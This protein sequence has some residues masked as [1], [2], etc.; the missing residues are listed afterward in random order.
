MVNFALSSEIISDIWISL[1]HNHTLKK[2]K[3]IAWRT[4][5]RNVIRPS[6]KP[7]LCG[8]SS[9]VLRLC[10]L[11]RLQSGVFHDSGSKQPAQLVEVQH[12]RPAPLSSS[13]SSSSYYSLSST[14]TNTGSQNPLSTSCQHF[15]DQKPRRPL[16]LDWP[17]NSS[18]AFF[19]EPALPPG[20]DIISIC[21]KSVGNYCVEE[22]KKMWIQERIG[23]NIVLSFPPFSFLVLFCLK[24]DRC[25][26]SALFPELITNLQ[27]LL[28]VLVPLYYFYFYYLLQVCLLVKELLRLNILSLGLFT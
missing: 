4:L 23:G 24:L 21:P 2:V 26:T 22:R 9:G 17:T 5:G 13:S 6:G 20:C 10:S 8:S 15:D 18:F 25:L 27:L 16:S 19:S 28:Q 7:S 1:A 14:L 12:P 11:W 3:P